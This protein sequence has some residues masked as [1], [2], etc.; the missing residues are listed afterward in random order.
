MISGPAL[1]QGWIL[2]GRPPPGQFHSHS[3]H[4]W[5]TLGNLASRRSSLL[6]MSESPIIHPFFFF[7]FLGPHPRHVEVP[8]P[9][10]ESASLQIPASSWIYHGSRHC[11]ILNPL[12]KAGD[13]T[14]ILKD[15]SQV[16]EPLS[17]K[18]SSH[19]FLKYHKKAGDK[20]N[21]AC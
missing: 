3:Y 5:S 16:H 17:H 14:H 11:Q 10:V 2:P 1:A 15:P 8:R 12:S 9:V 13:Q 18:G 19:Q 4:H 20:L 6:R 7:F 21:S